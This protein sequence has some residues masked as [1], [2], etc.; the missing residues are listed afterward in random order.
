MV[1]FMVKVMPVLSIRLK[2]LKPFVDEYKCVCGNDNY[3]KDIEWII[4]TAAVA[5]MTDA[6]SDHALSMT[7]EVIRLYEGGLLD[8]DY[9]YDRVDLTNAFSEVTTLFHELAVELINELYSKRL[10]TN[11][12]TTH[13]SLNKVVDDIL[14]L[15]ITYA[16]PGERFKK[17]F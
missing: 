10:I 3:L 5:G 6:V 13:L 16:Q 1:C 12:P 17:H 9:F 7:A 11:G 14:L 15:D 4:Y 2:N 8:G